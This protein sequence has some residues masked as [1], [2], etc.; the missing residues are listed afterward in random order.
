MQE[1]ST[2]RSKLLKGFLMVTK[3][4]QI[5]HLYEFGPFRLDPEK[6]LLTRSTAPVPLT[7]KVI[8]TLIVLIENRDRVVSK[9]DLMKILWPNSFVEESNLSQNVFVL[10]KALGDSSQERRYIVNLP[11]R[12]YQFTEAVREVEEAPPGTTQEVEETLRL[13][14][15]SLA[16]VVVERVVPRKG[17]IGM[18]TGIAVALA[19]L[20]GV[21]ALIDRSRVGRPAERTGPVVGLPA[22][23]MRPAV[24]VLGFRNL[25]GRGDTKWLSVALAE[26]L[27]TELAAGEHLR[28]IPG[29]QIA[30]ASRDVPW[31]EV[32]TLAKD[33][34]LRLRSNLGIDYV[35]LGSYTTLEDGKKTLIR[36]RPWQKMPSPEMKL[37]CLI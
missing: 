11:G 6:R 20:M 23:K 21:G 32:D 28:I 12:G 27:N 3:P 2:G 8:E 5:K 19:A 37:T 22:V 17:P 24:A 30:R 31:G 4:S 35:A 36:E 29:E 7:P 14:S 15:R 9:D 18:R 16:R 10:R 13:E 34:L 33:S 25:S 26:M 1:S